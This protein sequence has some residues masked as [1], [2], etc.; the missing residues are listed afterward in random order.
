MDRKDWNH[1][2][3]KVVK[4]TLTP[5]LATGD[6]VNFRNLDPSTSSIS[7]TCPG[8]A[9]HSETCGAAWNNVECTGEG[10]TAS[11]ETKGDSVVGF[12]I[13]SDKQRLTCDLARPLLP[14]PADNSVTVGDD[15]PATGASWTAEPESGTLP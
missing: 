4:I 6:K 3:W 8:P 11:G 7:I 14:G 13:R 2:N 15:V 1:Y 5:G 10:N 9:T 12:T